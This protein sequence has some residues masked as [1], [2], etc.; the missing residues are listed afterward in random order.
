M[1][2]F[3]LFCISILLLSCSTN[4]STETEVAPSKGTLYLQS[5]IVG[6]LRIGWL[7][8]GD[9]GTFVRDPKFGVDPV[10]TAMEKEHNAASAG[11][12]T[13]NGKI[14][15]VTYYSGKKENWAMEY[16]N[17]KL[18]TIDG[19]FVEAQKGLP[20]NY[21]LEGKFSANFH[22][23]YVSKQQT[24]TFN[25]DGTLTLTGQATVNTGVGGGTATAGAEK[26]T[27][28]IKGNTMTIKMANG[29]NSIAVIGFL[30]G[31]KP[32]IIINNAMFK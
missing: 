5:Y 6:G 25:N 15:A 11:T 10:N 27:Y 20:A 14:I 32:A 21:K 2:Y 31:T 9:D 23:G 3:S 12:Y 24:Y 7:W 13:K 30:P 8:L 16:D 22:I 29:D 28:V 1:K 4:A 26:G 18:N 17:G 19:W